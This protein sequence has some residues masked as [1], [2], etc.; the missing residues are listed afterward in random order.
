MSPRA[1]LTTETVVMTAMNIVD[2][3]GM[4]NLT[5]LRVAKELGV[6]SP[7]LYE[8]VKGMDGLTRKLRLKG[9]ELMKQQF[10]VALVGVSGDSAVRN[11][12]DSFRLFVKTHPSLY[13]LTIR[14]EVTDD[15]EI[16]NA[17]TD[18][19]DLI[20]T[21]LNDYRLSERNLVHAARYLRSTVHGF[22]TLEKSG[23]FGM[24]INTDDSFEIVKEMIVSNM[25]SFH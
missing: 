7:S 3:E 13:D 6:K 10:Q 1:G 25:K 17:A 22:A 14:S 21:V 11:L 23:G 18:I 16:R 2:S 12:A 9:L 20:F 4:E 5:L 15:A 8:H 19:L 24:D